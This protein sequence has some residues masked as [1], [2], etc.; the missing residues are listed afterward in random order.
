[1]TMKELSKYSEEDLNKLHFEMACFRRYFCN[2]KVKAC[3]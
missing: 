3:F 1:M 2:T